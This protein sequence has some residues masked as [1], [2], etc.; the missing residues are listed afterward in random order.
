MDKDLL[1][2]LDSVL[3]LSSDSPSGLL[4]KKSG[5]VAG[6]I[7]SDSYWVVRY[8]GKGYKAHRVVYGLFFG[9]F[10]CS[11]LIDHKDRN[12]QNNIPSNLRLVSPKG[13]T[14]NTGMLK[15]NKTGITGVTFQKPHYWR[16]NWNKNGK[17]FCKLFSIK[18]FGDTAFDL[19]T[20]YRRLKLIELNKEGESYSDN[21][22]V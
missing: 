22:G 7:D 9:E 10:P 11:C 16:A 19:A 12:R 17:T 13:N 2:I 14:Q 8:Q 18:K 1:Q 3:F 6:T 21:H 20:S 4:W 15:S 5:K